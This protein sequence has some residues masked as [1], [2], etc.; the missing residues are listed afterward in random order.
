MPTA[1]ANTSYFSL[2]LLLFLRGDKPMATQALLSPKEAGRQLLG[3]G[4]PLQPSV[5]TSIDSPRRA[6]FVVRAASTPPMKEQIGNS[7]LHPNN[8][9]LTWME[10]SSCNGLTVSLFDRDL[11]V[12][13][14]S[15]NM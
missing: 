3:G 14:I 7:G 10:A 9:S 6:S 12:Q 1:P 15:T 11:R 8:P 5:S 13:V 2:E 4:R